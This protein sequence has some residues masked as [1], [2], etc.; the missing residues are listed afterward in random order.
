MAIGESSIGSVAIGS[1]EE[2]AVSVVTP[3]LSSKPSAPRN[4]IANA[5][6]GITTVSF[7]QPLS[8]GGSP[9]TLFTVTA[10]TGQKST[11]VSS[12][13][14]ILTPNGVPVNFTVHAS[15]LNGDGPESPVSNTVTPTSLF[16]PIVVV[17]VAI[18]PVDFSMVGGDIQRFLA[19]VVAS[20][21]NVQRT[22]VWSCR[23]GNITP[24]GL[25]TAP[26]PQSIEQLDIITATS[27]DDPDFSASVSVSIA[28]FTVPVRIR[29]Y[30][31]VIRTEAGIAVQNAEVLVYDQRTLMP[32]TL[33]T[34]ETKQ[35]E[36]I[37]PV[38]TDELG[39][40]EFFTES[41][42]CGYTV[43]GY[44]IKP[45]RRDR[46]FDVATAVN[47]APVQ[48]ALD[49]LDTRKAN[50]TDM[51]AMGAGKASV[52]DLN[53]LAERVN[54]LTEIVN[55]LFNTQQSILDIITPQV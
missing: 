54:Q 11:G 49:T 44:G 33:Y 30:N 17:S 16:E 36:L 27:V 35:T 15:N 26:V 40:F 9:I 1:M 10:S 25:Y 21:T 20:G 6:D 13:I 23:L 19:K 8:N 24:T 47:L 38:L 55:G 43:Q 2:T 31:A 41:G 34:D 3:P 37:N 39:Y 46:I 50:Q 28:K 14:S 51:I 5:G 42:Q 48:L 52:A 7:D 22:V 32:V 45:Y 29:N 18:T 4:V 12:P 53:A